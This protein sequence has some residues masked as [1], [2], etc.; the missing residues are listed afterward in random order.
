VPGPA[1]TGAEAFGNVPLEKAP[2]RPLYIGLRLRGVL[3]QLGFEMPADDAQC[4]SLLLVRH[5]VHCPPI[6]KV[7]GQ[8]GLAFHRTALEPHLWAVSEAYVGAITA[9]AFAA[10]CRWKVGWRVRNWGD[11]A[12]LVSRSCGSVT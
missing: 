8:T 2:Q 7:N 4:I 6:E 5:I 11:F 9:F 12:A 1:S 3:F 10:G